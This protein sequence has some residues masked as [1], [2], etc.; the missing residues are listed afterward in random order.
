V[1]LRKFRIAARLTQEELAAR[2]SLSPD[3]IA[4]LESGKRRTPRE[5]TIELLAEALGLEAPER[6]QLAAAAREN[7]VAP[8]A[9]LAVGAHADAPHDVD[10]RPRWLAAAPTPLVDRAQELATILRSLATGGARLLTLTGPA[11]VGK[12]RLALAAAARLA[13][14]PPEAGDRFPDGVTL[15]D[16]TPVRDPDLVTGAIA[17]ALGLLDAGGRPTLERLTEAVGDERQ[18]LVLDNVEQVLPAAASLSELLASCAGLALLVTSRV[19]LRLRWEQ[20]LRIPPLPVPDLTAALPPPDVLYS[21]PSVAL[22]VGRARAQHADFVLTEQQ[23]PLVAQV[24][25]QLDGLPLALEL[26]AARLDVL[27]LSTLSRRLADRL[28]LLAVAAPDLPERQQSLEAAVGWSYDLLSEEEQRLFRCLGV[29]MGRVSLGAIT[30][31]ERAIGAEPAEVGDGEASENREAGHMLLRLLALAEKSLLLPALPEANGGRHAPADLED[32]EPAFAMLETVR[33]YAWER[34]VAQGELTAACRAHAHYFLALAERADPLLRGRDQRAWFLRLEREHDNLRAAL[35]WLL[36]QDDLDMATEREAALRMAGALGWFWSARGYHAEG[37]RWIEQALAHDWKAKA[38]LEVDRAAAAHTQ[39]LI[40]A[41]EF[42]AYQGNVELAQTVLEEALAL[43][44]RRQD[45]ACIAQ[46]LNY[47]GTCAL[48]AGEVAVAIPLLMEALNYGRDLPDP[49][50]SGI[51]LFLLGLAAAAQGDDMGAI[52][53]CEEALGQLEAAGDARVAGHVRFN[54]AGIVAQQSDLPRAAALVRAGFTACAALQD[55]LLLTTGV[56]AALAFVG[57]RGDPAQGARLLGAADALS[58]TTGATL[59]MAERVAADRVEAALRE[60]LTQEDMAA[61]YREGRA[62]AFDEVIALALTLLDEITPASS[63]RGTATDNAQP[64][65]RIMRPRDE[66]PL[67]ARELEALRLVAQGLSSKAIG[68]RLSLSPSTVNH[69][70]QSIFHK[71][72][73]DTRAQ[74]VAAAAQRGLL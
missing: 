9:H 48:F 32:D 36:E 40:G 27:S 23:S 29:F 47:L 42:L 30:A 67:S 69:H 28:Q 5:A 45:R 18:L 54:L 14:S 7:L 16:L 15:V 72:G 8:G 22:F 71:L 34:L 21:I 35:Q 38:D 66:N 61:A 24:V 44:R 25:T 64:M 65:E 60:E 56:R 53:R 12:T 31:V 55:R 70:M 73:V 68:R 3:A 1:L 10:H 2:A 26:A 33:E 62:L 43:A 59:G 49:H 11:G 39:A 4:A 19:P 57:E 74:A 37:M 41:G 46:A 58:Q 50:P 20:T 63:H 17:R 6:A 52:A 13:E 51:A